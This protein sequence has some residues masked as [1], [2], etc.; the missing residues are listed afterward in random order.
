MY[1]T[2]LKCPKK[3]VTVSTVVSGSVNPLSGAGSG[4]FR[5]Y[6]ENMTISTGC[7]YCMVR[8][9]FVTSDLKLIFEII[10]D[11]IYS[12]KNSNIF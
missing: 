11:R 3:V 8:V 9:I 1:D 7:N 6:N 2:V 12:M 5:C 4:T 10:F